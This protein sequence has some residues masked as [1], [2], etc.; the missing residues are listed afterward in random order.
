MIVTWLIK[1]Y[2]GL[3]MSPLDSYRGVD[4]ILLKWILSTPSIKQNKNVVENSHTKPYV[5]GCGLS[6]CSKDCGHHDV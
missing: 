1:K 2:P 6:R 5:Y 4:S 3:T